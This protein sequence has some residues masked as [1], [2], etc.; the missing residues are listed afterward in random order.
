MGGLNPI[1]PPSSPLRLTLTK[2]SGRSLVMDVLLCTVCKLHVKV[3][4]SGYILAGLKN[5]IYMCSKSV[6]CTIYV[7][8]RYVCSSALFCLCLSVHVQT[9][10]R[11]KEGD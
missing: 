3:L 7:T 9:H 11:Q 10:I 5:Y 2:L 1:M 4:F 6:N 8:Y